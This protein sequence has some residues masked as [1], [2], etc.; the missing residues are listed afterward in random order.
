MSCSASSS[1]PRAAKALALAMRCGGLS[2]ASTSWSYLRGSHQTPTQRTT[3]VWGA[4]Q[5]ERLQ[6]PTV[7]GSRAA[8]GSLAATAKGHG[9]GP[10]ERRMAAP[11]PPLLTS[12]ARALGPC[13]CARCSRPA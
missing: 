6:R 13:A 4:W 7:C 9:E 10:L 5:L 1:Q 2:L 8:N 11:V 12:R 3:H